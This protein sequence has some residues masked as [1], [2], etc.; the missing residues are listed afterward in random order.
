VSEGN[1]A[2]G[3]R[4]LAITNHYPSETSPGDAPCIRDQIEALRRRGIEVDVLAIDRARRKRSYLGAAARSIL[5]TFGRKRYDL[6]H[7][8]YGYAGLVARLQVR[9]PVVVTFRGSDLLSRRNRRIG[10]AV[11]RMVEGVIVM[12]AEMKRASGR[13]DARIIPFGVNVD[14][15][16]PSSRERARAEL[17]LH[18]RGKLV[19]FPWDPARPEKRFDVAAAAVETLRQEQDVRLIDIRDEPPAVVSRYMNACDAMVLVSDR[20]GA[21]MAVREAVACGLPVVSVDVGDVREVITNVDGC[22]LC[23]QEAEEVANKLRL[24]LRVSRTRDRPPRTVKDVGSVA[25]EVMQVYA[26]V[27]GGGRP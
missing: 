15:F 25:D 24:A 10:P 17:G 13:H 11:A 12:S 16:A 22:F 20:E 14:M 26:A 9:Y 7:A 4:V 3:L 5:S 6:V 19:L 2:G 18:A 27:L 23:K 8:Y 21:P 1:W